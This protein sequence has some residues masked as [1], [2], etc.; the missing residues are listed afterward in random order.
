MT[1]KIV[2][3]SGPSHFDLP[4]HL[5]I[6]FV[7]N[8]RGVQRQFARRRRLRQR[9]ASAT[10]IGHD[11]PTLNSFINYN[12]LIN[13]LSINFLLMGV[14]LYFYTNLLDENAFFGDAIVLVT[15]WQVAGRSSVGK[16]QKA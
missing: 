7:I 15:T 4:S 16:I 9:Q 8:L 11:L 3:S 10:H 2:H 12:F 14:I 5:S 1:H 13:S 6:N